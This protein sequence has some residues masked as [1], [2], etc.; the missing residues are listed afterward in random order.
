M[1]WLI[2]NKEWLFSGVGISICLGIF[3]FFKR[4]KQDKSNAKIEQSQS[5]G[6][7]STNVQA[8]KDVNLSKH[9]QK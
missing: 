9:V 8:G 6:S 4:N 2:N 3:T 7:H 1:Q 5:G